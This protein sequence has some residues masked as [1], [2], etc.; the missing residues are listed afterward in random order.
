[1]KFALAQAALM[2][3]V[4]ATSCA[5]AEPGGRFR[6]QEPLEETLK[7][8]IWFMAKVGELSPQERESLTAEANQSL[9]AWRPRIEPTLA[10]T[11]LRRE[12]KPALRNISPVAS[13]KFEAE[14]RRLHERSRRAAALVYVAELDEALSLSAEQRGRLYEL[15]VTGERGVGWALNAGT[16]AHIPMRWADK[17]VVT[18]GWLGEFF[19]SDDQLKAILQPWQSRRH[20]FFLSAVPQNQRLISA[21]RAIEP[22]MLAGGQTARPG[23]DASRPAETT[24]TAAQEQ[25]LHGYL[26]RLVEHIAEDA[27]LNDEQRKRL[28]LAGSLDIQRWRDAGALGVHNFPVPIYSNPPT[29]LE[30]L[31]TIRAEIFDVPESAFQKFTRGLQGDQKQRLATAENERHRFR[32]QALVEAVVVGFE[33]SAALTAA[34]CA[35][36]EERLTDSLEHC[37]PTP[38]WR[39]ECLKTIAA[40]PQEDL[41]PFFADEQWPA[42]VRQLK[43]LGTAAR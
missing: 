39:S 1:M 10:G 25:W 30:G 27:G 13:A 24:L 38:H 8:E 21:R 6:L 12:L 28:R 37:P 41:Q 16:T 3:L 22:A 17:N 31:S 23:R 14:F 19:I 42:A 18:A 26:D 9:D 43:Q 29:I 5:A 15:L 7:R 4:V 20:R 32:R 2:V 11:N 33:R 35:V 34:Q 36:L 40:L